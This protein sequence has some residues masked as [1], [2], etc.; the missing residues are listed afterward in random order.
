MWINN[1]FPLKDVG[2]L[3]FRSSSDIEFDLSAE[4]L[5]PEFEGREGLVS[6]RGGLEVDLEGLSKL[7]FKSVNS[8]STL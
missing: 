8:F 2:L 5:L 7:F 1:Y 3:F 4:P 6:R